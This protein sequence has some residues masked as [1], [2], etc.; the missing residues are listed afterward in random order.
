MTELKPCPFCGQEVSM[1]ESSRG[2]T[3]NGEFTAMYTVECKDC[4]IKFIRESKFRLVNG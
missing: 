3:S 1:K 2:H 4:K